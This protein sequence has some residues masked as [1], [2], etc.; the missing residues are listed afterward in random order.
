VGVLEPGVVVV[1][2]LQAKATEVWPAAAIYCGPEVVLT[3][4]G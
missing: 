1:V 3:V 2:V 4:A